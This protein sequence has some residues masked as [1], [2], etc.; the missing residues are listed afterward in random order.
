MTATAE[1]AD[2][3]LAE[4]VEQYLDQHTAGWDEQRIA[5]LRRDL[6][7]ALRYPTPGALAA[8][9]DP[10]TRQTPA[11]DVID[12]ALVDVDRGRC[13]RLLITMPPQEGKSERASH[14]GALWFLL[15]D[16]NRR[17]A[18]AS[19]ELGTA[20][21][22]GRAVRNDVET[23]EHL[24]LQIASDSKAANRWQ[25]LGFRGGM[26]CVGVGGALTGRAVD[27]MLIDDP[28]KGREQAD[29]ET[30]R[31]AV[32]DW[33]TSTARTRLA[34]GAPVVLILTR[35]HEDDLAGRLLAADRAL[36]AGERLWRHVNIPAQ[37]E[38]PDP[39]GHRPADSLGR[40]VG[41]FMLSAR[42]RTPAEWAEIRRDVGERDWSSLYQQNPTPLEG[43]V[44][45]W[46]W[47][48]QH[49]AA[50][51]QVPALPRVCVAVDTS[52]GGSDEAGIITAGRAADGHTYVLGDA[53]DRYTV[54]GWARRAWLACLDAEA[55]VLVYEANL[56][57]PIMRR[58]IPAAW[59]RLQQQ[60]RALTAR[61]VAAL[62]GPELDAA[63]LDAAAEL[64][65][66]LTDPDEHAD[67]HALG[68]QA[69][70][71]RQLLGYVDRI[72]RAPGHGPARVE[73]VHAT[74]GKLLRADPVAQLYRT[75]L[76]HHVGVYPQLEGELVAWQPGQPSP[77]RMD[78]LVWAVTHLSTAAA[79]SK[80][81]RARGRLPISGGRP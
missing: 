74:R 71:L 11:L 15:R 61:D 8:D 47:I 60:A 10:T 43:G 1:L 55:D 68:V 7:R 54:G 40:P 38:P 45:Q 24:D 25:V 4:Q 73:G 22:W 29:S 13:R 57:D 63:L 12:Q 67:D 65:G 75:G 19:F 51:E 28:M 9:L 62:D 39:D 33:W 53:S 42:G 18:L 50:P 2:P 26:Y 6:T 44:W 48:R 31:Q 17:I 46:E 80:V 52:A 36:P 37:A 49:R 81:R 21:R 76:V 79:P 23:Y 3:E 5:R 58:A 64:T 70:E 66:R 56:V 20:S 77:N 30:Y 34:P 27:L 72:A 69:D 16:P 14:Y 59:Q 78:A 32:W 41:E 35:W